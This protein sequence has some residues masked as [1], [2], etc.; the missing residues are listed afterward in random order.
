MLQCA[1]ADGPGGLVG[2][3]GAV[4]R[5]RE[6][7]APASPG[8]PPIAA[9][10]VMSQV[11]IGGLDVLGIFRTAPDPREQHVAE[12]QLAKGY[13]SAGHSPEVLAHLISLDLT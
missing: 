3:A 1:G 5:S 8:T 11:R 10:A 9:G 4:N 13:L 2:R 6:Q 7:S 12:E